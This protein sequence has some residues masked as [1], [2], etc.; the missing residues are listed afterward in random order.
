[1]YKSPQELKKL[2]T[3]K[4]FSKLDSA[5]LYS[6]VSSIRE[7]RQV[8]VHCRCAF[9][10]K[11][12]RIRVAKSTYLKDCHSMYRARLVHVVGIPIAPGEWMRIRP[13]TRVTFTL[14]FSA[15]PKRVSA[16]SLIEIT[17]DTGPFYAADV[18]RNNM[19]VYNLDLS[20]CGSN[21]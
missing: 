5:T 18:E 7:E 2:I 19:D 15:L 3:T 21:L 4:K 17:N 1:M 14:I 11:A 10:E 12:K 9:G 13:N 6:L 8:T 20:L 16:F